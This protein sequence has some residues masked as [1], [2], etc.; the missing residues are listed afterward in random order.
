MPGVT[1]PQHR[2]C[3]LEVGNSVNAPARIVG[4]VR[5]QKRLSGL[6]VRLQQVEPMEKRERILTSRAAR[7]AGPVRPDSSRDV[8]NEESTPD[9]QEVKHSAR[10]ATPTQDETHQHHAREKGDRLEEVADNQVS[11]DRAPH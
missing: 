7:G 1:G 11:S 9:P 3:G 5:R 6:A 8:G 4:Q 2:A 10:L